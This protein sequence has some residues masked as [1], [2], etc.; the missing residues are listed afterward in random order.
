MQ[1][2][3]PLD[4]LVVNTRF[5]TDEAARLFGGLGFTLT[6]QGRHAFGSVNHLMVF[7]DDYLELIG[8]PTDGGTLRQEILDN[9]G[10]IDG[11]VYKPASAD[12]VHAALSKA[13]AS[14]APLHA[15]TRPLELDGAWH[16]ASFRTVRYTPGAFEA[17]RVYYCQHLTPEL[18]WRPEWQA[19]ANGVL[20]LAGLTLVSSRAPSDALAYAQA[21]FGQVHLGAEGF[22][23]P[24]PG[25]S[26]TLLDPEA[27]ARRYD[28][29][30]CD[31]LGRDSFFGAIVLRAGKPEALQRHVAALGEQVR[32]Q[33]WQRDGESGLAVALPGLNT[34]LDFVY[35][36]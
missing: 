12:D 10:G 29:L 19:H 24:S 13:G 20:G 5:D 27:Y 15:F 2:A 11:L 7:Q 26:V 32:S 4:H 25:F 31:S 3:L 18:V 36:H 28:D 1:N 22:S 9:P 14:V 21:A 33:S 8:L 6:P 34:L 16:E 30:G 35:E 17:G 23:I